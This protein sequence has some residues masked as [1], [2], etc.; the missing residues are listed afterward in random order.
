METIYNL[1]G[2]VRACTPEQ[3]LNKLK[4]FLLDAFGI[5]RIA[6]VT[7][8]D[9]IGIPVSICIRP[10]S[11]IL[12]TSQ[13]KGISHELAAISAIMESIES[14]HAE[15][16]QGEKILSSYEDLAKS[17]PL[18]DLAYLFRG[19]VSYPDI[20]SRQFA[21]LQVR[22]I[23]TD[24]TTYLPSALITLDSTAIRT[25][26]ELFI[27]TSNGLAAGNTLEEA[28]C[29]G[30]YES[31]ERD[32]ALD[33]I[34][35]SEEEQSQRRVRLDTIDSEHNQELIR[36]IHQAEIE[37]YV[38]ETTNRFGIASFY[39]EIDDKNS[40]RGLGSFGGWGAHL[41][42]EVALSRAITEAVQSRLTIIVGSREDF[43][44][45]FYH[46]NIGRHIEYTGAES[47]S[48][49][50]CAN[51]I[52]PNSFKECIAVLLAKLK[53]RNINHVFVYDHT[54][55][56]LDISVVHVIVPGLDFDWKS[57]RMVK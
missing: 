55:P 13:G 4:P 50:E 6:D 9:T 54:R 32:C 30:L 24:Q 7:G 28:I 34:Q 33:F 12:A 15:R 26:Q 29:H 35:L 19:F 11:Q 51:P 1:G 38:F 17:Q 18:P 41:S 39:A 53:Q 49:H 23:V 52:M 36:R 10:Q 42:R 5:T 48:F 20:Y 37:L 22:D 27:G 43:L 16:I 31:I 46:N 8:L 21:W 40:I 45:S 57:H 56:E 14:W 2:T 3:T 47:R 25:G 44:P